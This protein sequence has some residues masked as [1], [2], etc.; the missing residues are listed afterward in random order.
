[1]LFNDN[2]SQ[3]TVLYLLTALRLAQSSLTLFGLS[4][5]NYRRFTF[6]VVDAIESFASAVI[7]TAAPLRFTRLRVE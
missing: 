1:M 2:E 6:S 3:R 5:V 7:F 4:T